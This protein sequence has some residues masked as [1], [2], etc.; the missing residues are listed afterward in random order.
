VGGP[1]VQRTVTVFNFASGPTAGD[2]VFGPGAITIDGTAASNFSVV[3][4]GCSGQTVVPGTGCPVVVAFSPS[5]V[6]SRYALLHAAANGFSDPLGAGLNGVGQAAA[7]GGG[8]GGS[9]PTSSAST[10]AD[11]P[12]PVSPTVPSRPI[13][14]KPVTAPATTTTT[15]SA[16]RL[17]A[18]RTGLVAV[19]LGCRGAAGRRCSGTI[20]LLEGRGARPPRV[21]V[22]GSTRFRLASGG[23]ET[24]KIRLRESVR[25]AL[26]GDCDGQMVL[27][28][29]VT[30][31][32][33]GTTTTRDL[34]VTLRAASCGRPPAAPTRR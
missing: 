14:P 13:T 4:D 25:R 28:R 21:T 18:D 30:A 3:S 22:P 19:E 11:P 27:V 17:V 5:A 32:A 20:A 7:G 9:T 23:R 33:D 10:A 15:L 1:S 8:G 26:A 12:P 29:L 31:Q 16:T 34:R 6:G 2:A 24:L